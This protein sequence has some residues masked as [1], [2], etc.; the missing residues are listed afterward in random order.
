[1]G[2]NYSAIVV[3]AA[4]LRREREPGEHGILPQEAWEQIETQWV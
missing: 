2:S 4:Q 1:M 3:D